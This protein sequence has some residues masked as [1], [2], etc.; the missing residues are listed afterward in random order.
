MTNYS[1]D[2][3]LDLA[4]DFAQ[5]GQKQKAIDSLEEALRMGFDIKIAL[6]LSKLYRQTGQEDQAYAVI[7]TVPDLFSIEQVL[8]EY[9]KVLAANHYLIEALQV[10]N[11][12]QGELE[13]LVEPA[14]P[15]E[16]R[17][18]MQQ[19]RSSNAV[20]LS[21][22]QELFK[23]D[24]PT[25]LAFAQSVLIDP[26][27]DSTVKVALTEDLVKLGR[28]EEFTITILGQNHVFVPKEVP[29]L[30]QDTVYKEVITAIAGKFHN[31]PS[32]LPLYLAE[33]NFALG[34]LYPCQK[35]FISNPDAFAKDLLNFLQKKPVY[36]YQKLLEKIYSK[37]AG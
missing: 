8:D 32:E 6:E 2:N 31:R 12:T 23:L 3:L 35:T 16:Q 14:K 36:S 28:E 13:F 17:T 22:Y 25:Y 34:K 27:E 10:R 20:T 9:E 30:N 33:A 1:Q 18:I 21:Q 7:K 15:S 24:L 37:N 19:F 4:K 29:M 5:Q 11:L 26:L